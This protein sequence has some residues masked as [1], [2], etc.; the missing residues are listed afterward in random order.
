MLSVGGVAFGLV[1]MAAVALGLLPLGGAAFGVLP[2]GGFAAGIPAAVGGLAVATEYA[3]GGWAVAAHANDAIVRA[4][5]G[6]WLPQWLFP[7]EL[8]LIAVLA[9]VPSLIYASRQRHHL[10]PR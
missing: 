8:A 2:I 1:P 3:A 6:V 7:V 9:I 10:K 4:W 5:L